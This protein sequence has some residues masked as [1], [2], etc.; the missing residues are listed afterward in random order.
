MNTKQILLGFL[1]LGILSCSNPKNKNQAKESFITGIKVKSELP[2]HIDLPQKGKNNLKA[3]LFA[4]T[5][6]YIPLETN[7][8]SLLRRI[9]YVRMNDSIIAI[10]DMIRI[11]LFRH[12]GTFIRQIG[13]RGKGPGEYGTIA[14]FHLHAD[15][16][17]IASRRTINKYTL[18]GQHKEDI[19][20]KHPID[21][22][23][24][25][26]EG[27]FVFFND[28]EGEVYYYDLAFNL[29]DTL[30]VEYNVPSNRYEF[31]MFDPADAFF[32]IS[33]GKMLFTNYKSDTIWNL[34]GAKKKA[35]YIFNLKNELLP[36]DFQVENFHGDFERYKWTVAKYQKINLIEISETL[37]ILK[38]SWATGELN[39]IYIHNFKENI[40][41]VYDAKYIYDDLIGR[42]KLRTILEL[43]TEE[44]FVTAIKATELIEALEE[45]NQK[46]AIT[47]VHHNLWKRNM[48]KVKFDDNPILVIFKDKRKL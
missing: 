18:D 8:K 44:A 42:I 37:F 40:T 41:D 12:D 34:S 45:L 33:K 10:S 29:K 14:N 17:Y 22:F 15:T 43:S 38:K 5:I 25:I 6:V 28:Y 26:P 30:V 13:Q 20:F 35:T 39:T 36:W 32:Q 24:D 27:G 48:S 31:Q 2:Y 1:L 9:V 47:K 7:T 11:L 16:I 3:S 19:T 23:R 46:E 4:D 21:Y